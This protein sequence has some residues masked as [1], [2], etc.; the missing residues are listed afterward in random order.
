M[1]GIRSLNIPRFEQNIILAVE[2]DHIQADTFK[3]VIE[4]IDQCYH[5]PSDEELK[6]KA[7]NQILEGH[8]VEALRGEWRNGYWCDIV[9]VYVNMGDSYVNTIIHHR[10]RGFFVSSIGGYIERH[11]KE[12]TN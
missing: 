6:M 12:F 8:G 1:K 5:R 11:P 3:S 10:D 9:L 7:F 2:H 4:W